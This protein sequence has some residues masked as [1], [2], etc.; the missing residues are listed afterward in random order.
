LRCGTQ[1][2][3]NSIGQN[4]S[5]AFATRAAGLALKADVALRPGG[6]IAMMIAGDNTILT[7]FSG[8]S[9]D[10]VGDREIK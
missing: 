1:S 9:P 4:R 8:E 10:A 6:P 2:F 3:F 5:P 7:G